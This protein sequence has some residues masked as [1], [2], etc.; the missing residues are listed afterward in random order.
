MDSTTNMAKS[1]EKLY[2]KAKKY[3]ETSAE[4]LALNTVDK[5]ADVLSSL[6]FIVLLVIV[7]AM[8][9]LFINVGLSLF[10]GS[11]L[12]AY[13]LG[14]FIVSAFYLVVALILYVYKDKLIKTPVANLII[15]KLLKSKNSA[16]KVFDS[17][18]EGEHD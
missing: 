8:F 5:T 13:Y 9:T 12:N 10:L 1:V 7:V 17:L 11:L 4:L 15:E 16:S 2:E 6:T 14:F 18:K 3:T